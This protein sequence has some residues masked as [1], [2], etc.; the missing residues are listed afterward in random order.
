MYVNK[1]KQFFLFVRLFGRTGVKRR[2]ICDWHTEAKVSTAFSSSKHIISVI[3]FH[4]CLAVP[5]WHHSGCSTIASSA[6]GFC[7]IFFVCLSLLINVDYIQKPT[8]LSSCWCVCAH[9]KPKWRFF[10]DDN[11]CKYTS[12]WKLN[13]IHFGML[14]SV[15]MAT[16][17]AA[18]FRQYHTNTQS[19]FTEKGI[20]Y[21]PVNDF[22]GH[23]NALP[24]SS[25]CSRSFSQWRFK[26]NF[27]NLMAF[28]NLLNANIVDIIYWHRR[29]ADR[30]YGKLVWKCILA[31]LEWL[32]HTEIG[33]TKKVPE[34]L[35]VVFFFSSFSDLVK[36]IFKCK[37]FKIVCSM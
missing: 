28:V 29:N 14:S 5:Y 30:W 32:F 37:V 3:K 9:Q 35:L 18:H 25:F 21:F 8:R 27:F 23:F 6:H 1:I 17:A 13:G 31:I 19:L 12:C 33:P 2:W 15:A 36:W 22:L 4:E 34:C 11:I 26:Y 16:M 10:R 20:M 24:F 7:S